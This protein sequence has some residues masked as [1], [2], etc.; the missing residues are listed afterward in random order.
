MRVSLESLRGESLGLLGKAGVLPSIE[1]ER[2][3]LESKQ[4]GVEGMVLDA[5]ADEG[6]ET[7]GQP[8]F[9]EII[10]GS[11]LGRLRRRRGGETSKD[12]RS[13]VEWEIVE[14]GID[15]DEG[16]GKDAG[17]TGTTKRKLGEMGEPEDISMRG[18]S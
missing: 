13:S 11:E 15:E 8:W 4:E 18:G 3:K 9:E 14:M 2:E 17:S 6:R 12:G 1:V 16:E 7:R 10:E 5:R